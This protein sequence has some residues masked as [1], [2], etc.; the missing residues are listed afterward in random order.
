MTRHNTT[1]EDAK[2]WSEPHEKV[3]YLARNQTMQN[4]S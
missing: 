4:Y 2:K 1:L 3:V